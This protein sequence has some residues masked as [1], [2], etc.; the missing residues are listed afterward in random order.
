MQN[1]PNLVRFSPKNADFTKNKAK[2]KPNSNP[3]Q[4]QFKPKQSQFRTSNFGFSVLQ[5]LQI[6]DSRPVD[7]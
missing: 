7:W 2:N 1:K 4:T 5:L 3:I 6:Q